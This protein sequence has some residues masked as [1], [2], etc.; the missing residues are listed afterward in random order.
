MKNKALLSI[1]IGLF[2]ASC[3]GTKSL[4]SNEVLYK[5]SGINIQKDQTEGPWEVRN[6][7]EKLTSL[8]WELWDTPNGALLGLPNIRFIPFRLIIYNWFYNEKDS[9]VAYWMRN[10]FGE[11]PVTIQSVQP[12]LKI[13]KAVNIYENYGHFGTQGNYTLAYNKK[14]NKAYV[15]Y[16][17]LI[18]KAYSYRSVIYRTDSTQSNISLMLKK[19]PSFSKLTEGDDFVLK[20]IRNEK[21]NLW[22]YL[23][24]NGFYY[25]EDDDIIAEADTTQHN[26]QLDL[27]F[28]V[29][30]NQTGFSDNRVKIKSSN[31]FI[32]SVEQAKSEAN[33][34]YWDSGKIRKTLIDE[35]VDVSPGDTF[36]LAKTNRSISNLADLGVFATPRINYFIDEND[37]TQL[38][39]QIKVNSL[40]AT[41]LALEAEGMYRN[42]G[43]IGPAIGFNLTQ[44]N[45]FGGAENLTVDGNAYY[46]FPIGVFKERISPSSGFS[47]NSQISSPLVNPP[48]KF[49]RSQIALPRKHIMANFSFNDR[50]DY[51]TMFG[52]DFSY[53]YSWKSGPRTTHRINL[54]NATY[55]DILNTTYRFD[56]L[57][58]QNPS[59]RN[60]LVNQFIIGSGYK[61]SY[62][63]INRSASRFGYYFEAGV[64]FSGNLLGAAYSVFDKNNKGNHKFLGVKFAQYTLLHY[65]FR[66]YW[67]VG[68]S[69]QLAFRHMAGI[70]LSYGNSTEMPYIRQFTIGGSNSLRPIN[71]RSVGPGRYIELNE[72][73]VNQVGDVKFETNLEYRMHIGG[74]LNGAVFADIGN[75]FLLN[76]DPNRPYSQIRW[77]KIIQDS[78]FTA[79]AGLRLNLNFLILRVDY[80]A[81][82][83][84][85][86]FINGYKWIWQN[87]LPLHGPVIG[88]GLPF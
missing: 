62:D 42:S 65:E 1:V 27:R 35:I 82:L 81:V 80:G 44:L 45:V 30:R 31:F 86:I 3:S 23:Q 9:G 16:K 51:F 39:A 52:F 76:E 47:V 36:S 12:E 61:F 74:R 75:I 48:L 33:Y 54:V 43:Y 4:K 14:K 67:Q 77:N 21:L 70:G 78:Y 20:N 40:D 88:F 59:L 37:S 64:D 34:Y 22:N 84:A 60:N 32:D 63:R 79:G 38:N 26:K 53:G 50:K 73:E 7:V 66:G 10:N 56:T 68:A 69:N 2:L 72:A 83:Y 8:Y 29:L 13:Q 15:H 5:G 18:P 49:I 58:A 11:A 87:K 41:S 46:D 24:N 28:T 25:V 57:V 19:Y 17:L 55:S 71:A 6:S 85:P